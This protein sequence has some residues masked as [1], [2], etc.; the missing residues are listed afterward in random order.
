MAGIFGDLDFDN[1]AEDLNPPAGTYNCIV[2]KAVVGPTKKGDKVGLGITY[3]IQDEG[4]W[5]GD[6]IFEWKEIDGDEDSRATT[7][8]RIRL[9][10]LGLTTADMNA[11]NGI[12]P[13][14]AAQ[15]AL[16]EAI[17]GKEVVVD[18]SRNGEYVNVNRVAEQ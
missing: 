17:T 4:K 7:Y 5:E 16:T 1:V 14:E 18:V 15:K 11:I 12:K 10:N 8:L 3:T 13:A 2:T 9:G 6:T